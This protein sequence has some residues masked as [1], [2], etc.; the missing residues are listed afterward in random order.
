[1]NVPKAEVAALRSPADQEAYEKSLHPNLLHGWNGGVNVGFALTGGNSET[2]NLAIAFLANRPTSTDKISL[3]ANTV[4]AT[5]NAPG[6]FPTTTANNIQGG[7]R[8]DRNLTPK[9]FAFVN[10]DFMSDSLQDLNLRSVF[11]GGL[12]YHAIKRERTVLDFLGGANYTHESY[13]TFTRNFGALTLGEE[14]LQKLGV[15]TVLKQ[16]FYF[17]PNLSDTGEYRTTFDLGTVTKLNAWLG[18]QN[19]FSDVYVTNPPIGKKKNDIVFT[20]GLNVTFTH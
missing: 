5:N 6:A 14:F 4:Y 9:L 17:Y 1:V 13:T 19:S 2:T 12:G 18:W 20:T 8:Y 16:K 10:G 7:A 15:G 3:Y 11:G